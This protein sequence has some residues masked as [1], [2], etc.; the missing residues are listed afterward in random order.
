MR[1]VVLLLLTTFLGCKKTQQANVQTDSM[2]LTGDTGRHLTVEVF[3]LDKSRSKTAVHRVCAIGLA[4]DETFKKHSP[5]RKLVCSNEITAA[6]SLLVKL[7]NLPYPA[8]ISLFHDENLNEVLDFATFNI[9]IARKDGPIEGVG[10]LEETDPQMKFSKPIWVEV[11]EN[12]RRANMR[13]DVSPFWKFVS[14]ESWQYLYVKFLE[15]A[16]EINHRGKFNNP[17]CTKAE[18]CL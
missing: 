3:N 10:V 12:Q 2:N 9:I 14:E 5:D 13:Y 11:G 17:F 8:Y 16:R 15:K 1:I 6:G 4:G 7:R 18:E